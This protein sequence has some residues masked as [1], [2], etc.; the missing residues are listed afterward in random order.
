MLGLGHESI[1][2]TDLA[3]LKCLQRIGLRR[4]DGFQAAGGH[5][6][7]PFAHELEAA[8]IHD[9]GADTRHAA[10]AKTSHAM[11]E[12]GT[13]RIAATDDH[14]ALNSKRALRGGMV[15]E[16]RLGEIQFQAR[17]KHSSAAAASTVAMGAVELEIGACASDEIGLGIVRI[18]DR[19][20]LG[21]RLFEPAVLHQRI[22]L[23][24]EVK[25]RRIEG[26][27]IGAAIVVA[28]GAFGAAGVAPCEF[29]G[30]EIEHAVAAFVGGQLRVGLGVVPNVIVGV[31]F[32]VVPMEHLRLES[33]GLALDGDGNGLGQH[34][35]V[36][37]SK[38]VF[39]I[40]A[41]RIVTL[42][43]IDGLPAGYS[44]NAGTGGAVGPGVGADCV[45]L[46]PGI[47]LE[48]SGIGKQA[49]FT[50]ALGELGLSTT[51]FVGFQS[52]NSC[53]LYTSPS[54]RD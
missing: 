20:M 37:Q 50:E 23:T 33:L 8:H 54:P 14:G 39:E 15:D 29:A 19:R 10:W 52:V 35:A 31:P 9:V 46:H 7:D 13:M 3:G 34:A 17:F 38:M 21:Q 44:H 25:L 5:G 1:E 27:Q 4:G 6:G 24:V 41:V 2:R 45:R 12:R 30:A 47:G 11:V 36:G 22:Q 53:L 43:E 16:L 40:T 28:L 49:G 48:R 26:E 18:G 32:V 42:K 51:G